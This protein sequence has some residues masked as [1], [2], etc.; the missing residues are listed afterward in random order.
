MTQVILERSPL[1]D[2]GPISTIDVDA[3]TGEIIP[4]SPTL[5]SQMQE[6]ANALA[7][8]LPHKAAPRIRLSDH[9][10]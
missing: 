2:T 6:R 3:S 5:I 7:R 1:L 8:R 9:H 4:L 10:P